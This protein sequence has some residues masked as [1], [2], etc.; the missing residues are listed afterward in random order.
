MA[1]APSEDRKAA[2]DRAF[3]EGPRK[4]DGGGDPPAK[5]APLSTPDEKK[6]KTREELGRK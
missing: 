5:F 3:R 2:V 6:K 4:I 1:D